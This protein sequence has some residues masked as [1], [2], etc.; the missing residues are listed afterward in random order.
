MSL[1]MDVTPDVMVCS[2]CG[3]PDDTLVSLPSGE[4]ACE[5]CAA[6]LCVAD[7]LQDNQA[8]TLRPYQQEA[9]DSIFGCLETANSA[10]LVLPTGC[11]K[12][13]SFAK[14]IQDWPTGRVVVMAHRDELIRQAADKIQRVTGEVCDIEMGD[15]RADQRSL[16]AAAKVVVT[17]VQT[18]SRRN[19]HTRF[20]PEE[21]GLLI[22]DEAHH[23]V[24]KTYLAVIDYFRQNPNLKVLGV[25]A[26]PDRTDEAALG[27]VFESVAYE[28]SLPQAI[29][30]GWLVPI[31]QQFVHIE[32]LDLSAVK[33]TAGDLNQ[34]QLADILEE[35][36]TA[37]QIVSATMQ[38]ADGAQT[39]I[40]AASVDQAEQMAMIANRHKPGCAEWICGDAVRCPMD[41]RRALLERFRNRDFQC[42]FNC[43]ILL[44]G[45]D[46]DNISVVVPKATKSRSLYAQMIG[47]GTRPLSGLVDGLDSADARRA[48]IAASA[49][50]HMLALDFVGNSGRHK[51]IH[52]GDVLGGSYDD[53]IVA[54]ATCVHEVPLEDR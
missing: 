39:L 15:Y 32:G 54:E 35:E 24:A 20:H 8:W 51:L 38:V 36:K 48:A 16:H 5:C 53:E 42:L 19:R 4:V 40:F 14:V 13:I 37:Q 34:R 12:T 44:E 27:R 49:K 6:T 45:F 46:Q 9:H 23:A 18:M 43:A 28:Y 2:V 25:T 31:Q 52:A 1:C 29:D 47:R 30:D 41:T 26:T 33:T 11:G 10:L 22:I 7:T 21:F 50:G 17:S 3:F